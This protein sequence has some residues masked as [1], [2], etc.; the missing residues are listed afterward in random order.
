MVATFSNDAKRR[1]IVIHQQCATRWL[2][3]ITLDKIA[4]AII[5]P[6]TG[7]EVAGQ[8]LYPVRRPEKGGGW[9]FPRY[10]IRVTEL[11]LPHEDT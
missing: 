11:S 2:P 4:V 3:V 5:E 10:L 8:H 6:A 1:K 7:G 9:G